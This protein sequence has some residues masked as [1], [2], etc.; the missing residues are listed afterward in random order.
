MLSLL[1][2]ECKQTENSSNPFRI[3][4]FF[5]LSYSSGIEM[6]KTFIQSHSSLRNHTRFQ[7]KMGKVYTRFQTKTPQKPYPMGRH[8]PTCAL[9]LREGQDLGHSFSQ[10]LV[11]NVTPFKAFEWRGTENQYQ[12]QNHNRSIEKVNNLG[13]ERRYI[14]KDPSQNSGQRNISYT[15]Y[16]TKCFTQTYR[17]LYA[18]AM[19]VLT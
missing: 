15:R 6:I 18:D 14:N 10:L 1:R 12:N 17:D 4:I 5:F 13:N 8:I 2:L 11:F 3:C 19:L 16:P 7:T 9:G